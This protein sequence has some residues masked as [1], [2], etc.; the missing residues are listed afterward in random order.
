MAR[1][2][3][4]SWGS[5]W[6]SSFGASS[7]GGGGGGSNPCWGAS[8]GSS[9]GASWGARLFPAAGGARYVPGGIDWWAHVDRRHLEAPAPPFEPQAQPSEQPV[10]ARSEIAI[11]NA[12]R[13]LM[14]LRL[15][16][17]TAPQPAEKELSRAVDEELDRALEAMNIAMSAHHRRIMHERVAHAIAQRG[18]I[19]IDDDE[20][21]MMM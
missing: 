3:G 11:A 12:V 16:P 21:L 5:A 15:P 6:G 10:E 18:G 1:A 17:V 14:A 13:R 7:G 9:W 2:W 8:W 19:A 4:S 20:F